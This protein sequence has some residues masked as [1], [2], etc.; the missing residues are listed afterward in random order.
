ML[1]AHEFIPLVVNLQDIHTSLQVV[2]VDGVCGL[3]YMGCEYKLSADG[4]YLSH[5]I[6]RCVGDI[7][8]VVVVPD[9]Y[10]VVLVDASRCVI[11][12]SG[13]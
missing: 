3:L 2:D 9:L 1:L 4:V 13:V 8:L 12:Q 11:A 7:E 5:A 6:G 10:G